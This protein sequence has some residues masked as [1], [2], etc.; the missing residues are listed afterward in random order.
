MG[1]LGLLT[2]G[3]AIQRYNAKPARDQRMVQRNKRLNDELAATLKQ[4]PKELLTK[5]GVGWRG[6]RA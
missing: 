1:L 3:T 4:D 2:L 6:A 5:A